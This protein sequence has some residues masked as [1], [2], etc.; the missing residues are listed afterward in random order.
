MTVQM[1]RWRAC[2]GFGWLLLSVAGVAADRDWPAY[3]GD[4][5][6]TRHSPLTQINRENV[7]QLRQAWS[8]DTREK[9]DTQIQP[10]AVG[11]VVR[12]HAHAQDHCAGFRQRQAAV[13][14]RSGA[15]RQ[16]RTAG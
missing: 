1:T 16:R 10:I 13:D 9:G 4:A 15:R 5:G 6:K 3:G 14:F 7:R 12:L 11:R 8:Y 2:A